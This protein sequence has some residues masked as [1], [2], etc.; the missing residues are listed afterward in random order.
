MPRHYARKSY[1]RPSMR[2]SY[3]TKRRTVKQPYGNRYGNDAF[4]KCENVEPLA[5]SVATE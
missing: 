2:R 3:G 5:T 4:V 1:A